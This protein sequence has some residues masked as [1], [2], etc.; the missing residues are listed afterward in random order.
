[1]KKGQ[2]AAKLLSS[3]YKNMEKVQRLNRDGNEEA[4]NF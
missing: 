3:L 4:C 1:M 2:S